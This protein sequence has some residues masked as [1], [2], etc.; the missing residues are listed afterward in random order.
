MQVTLEE[1]STV[2]KRLTIEIP[3]TEVVSE[4]DAAYNSLKKTAKIKGFR[5][6]KAPRSV[7]VNMYKKDVHA[8]VVSKLVQG[9]FIEAVKEKDLMPIGEPQLDTPELDPESSYQYVAT[10]EIRPVIE[11]VEF[12]GLDLKKSKYE[13]NDQEIE[14]QLN[15]LRK[16]F[17]KREDIEEVRAIEEGDLV[18]IDFEGFEGGAP[19]DK[20]PKLE[21]HILKVGDATLSKD[22]DDQLVGMTPGDDK[23]FD[24]DY[25]ED[26]INKELAG[27]K[28][29]YQVKIV[30]IKVEILPEL[31]DQFAKDLLK[32]ETLEQLKDEIRK[33]LSEG[34][35]KRIEQEMNEQ[36]FDALI[37]K[38]EFEVPDV[39]VNYELDGIITEA[40]QAFAANNISLEQIGQTKEGLRE[41]YRDV[42]EKQ[43]RRHLILG[44]IIEHEELKLSDEELEAGYEDMSKNFNQPVE[45]IKSFYKNNPDKIEYFKHTLLEKKAIK[46]IIDNS[47]VEEVDPMEQ[48][49]SKDEDTETS[50]E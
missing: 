6:G 46:L 45:G 34:Y 21:G 35:E 33:N 7:L 12:G 44:S 39:M 42:A 29:K 16:R 3:E 2:K 38:S 14:I 49:V 4:L 5:P 11:K 18:Q 48:I 19:T 15:M 47:N 40:E 25:P 36:I 32:F 43:V 28:I 22:F 50:E 20:A 23:I 13:A 10:I 26:Y 41:Q 8:D 31:D 27:S 24:I 9:T 30:S 1:L 37:S 17:A